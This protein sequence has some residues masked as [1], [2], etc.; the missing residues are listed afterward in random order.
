MS[1]KG[2]AWWGFHELTDPWAYRLVKA[3][4]IRPGEMVLDIGAGRGA[5][6]VHLLNAGARVIAVELHPERA[7]QLRQRFGSRI[8]VVQADAT[9]L[10][11]PRGEFKVVANPPF[12]LTAGLLRRL[13]SSPGRMLSADIVVPTRTAARWAAGRGPP[14]TSRS[15]TYTARTVARLPTRAFRPPS[16]AAAAVLRLERHR[17]GGADPNAPPGIHPLARNDSRQPPRL[18]GGQDSDAVLHTPPRA[19]RAR[20][21]AVWR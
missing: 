17:P 3:A 15:A 10:R 21:A 4:G 1:A 19:R 14:S 16:P 18:P 12:G 7:R 9:D 2:Q 11:L 13:V 8:I 20:A 6:T 5:I